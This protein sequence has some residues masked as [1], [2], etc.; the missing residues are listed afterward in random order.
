MQSVGDQH[1]MHPREMKKTQNQQPHG[2]PRRQNTCCI[3]VSVAHPRSDSVLPSHPSESIRVDLS[4]SESIQV[5][6]SRVFPRPSEQLAFF[7]RRPP[8]SLA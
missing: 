7:G 8:S 5:D 6:P 3:P 4:R 2:R 1:L